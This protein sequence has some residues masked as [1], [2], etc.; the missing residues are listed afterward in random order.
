MPKRSKKHAPKTPQQSSPKQP[1]KRLLNLDLYRA[2]AIILMVLF[3]FAYDLHYFGFSDIDTT[4]SPFFVPLRTF[5][6]ALFMSAV[7]MSFYLVY[8]QKF[9]RQKYIKRL[10]LLGSAAAAISLS[11]YWLFPES[12]VY[13]GVLHLIFVSSIIGPF[14][15]KKPNI[16]GAV[17]VAIVGLYLVGYR[18][19]L[20][21]WLQPVLGL[22]LRHTEDLAPFIPWFGVVL[23]GIFAMHYRVLDVVKIPEGWLSQKL[24][25]L[26]RH[27]LLIY[28]IHQ[29]ILFAIL[30]AVAYL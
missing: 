17:G 30:G 9:N 14:C 24:A 19:P 18:S 25:F 4:Q 23:L 22:P 10:L 3:H 5:I 16:A 15:V 21:E 29:P 13:F 6:V 28:L 11:S 20:F 12:W 27:S 1:T 26:G 8:R 7:G 2:F